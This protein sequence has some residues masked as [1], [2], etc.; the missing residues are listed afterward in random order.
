MITRTVSASYAAVSLTLLSFIAFGDKREEA[1]A[2]LRESTKS[3]RQFCRVLLQIVQ[4]RT[5]GM[6]PKYDAFPA[7]EALDATHAS[8]PQ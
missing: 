4:N 5:K 7:T 2:G 1:L 6:F 8:S 3:I